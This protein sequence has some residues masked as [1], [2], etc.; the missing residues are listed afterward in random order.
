MG[1]VKQDLLNMK[2][3]AVN[4]R[5]KN[6]IRV[7]YSTCGV[8]AGAKEVLEVLTEEAKTRGLDVEVKKCGCL[9]L[10]SAEP[11]VE[12]NVE[13]AP[14]V[15]YGKVNKDVAHKIMDEHVCQKKLVDGHIYEI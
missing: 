12:V 15:F 8:A 6:W 14:R 7:G 3:V 10:C 1:I 9:G 4:K 11:L 5:A 13:G 2:T